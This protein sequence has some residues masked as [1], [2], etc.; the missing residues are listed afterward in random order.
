M[1][2]KRQTRLECC[3]CHEINYL[4]AKNAKKHPEKMELNK[5]CNSCRKVTI[6]KETKKK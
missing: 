4:T 3:E 2:I 1:A 5:F 6:H